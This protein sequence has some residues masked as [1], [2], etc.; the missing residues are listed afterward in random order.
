MR[1]IAHLLLCLALGC[2]GSSGAGN[3]AGPPLLET[4]EWNDVD[5]DL[6]A[7]GIIDE[8]LKSRFVEEWQQSHAEKKPTLR[9]YPIRNRTTAYIN[10]RFFT[11]QLEQALVRA[12]KLTVVAAAE[13][14]AHTSDGALED[15][16]E[17][18]DDQAQGRHDA[19]VDLV[20]NGW[21][22]SQEEQ[23]AAVT[24]RSYLTSV[25]IVDVVT[26]KKLWIGQKRIRKQIPR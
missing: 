6:V 10:H 14:R 3:T 20:L 16:R 2:A 9:L 25:E 22:L 18:G 8:A 7:R 21:I 24:V 26:E 5:A 11:K 4:G 13:E 23:D 12:G 19:D 1:G 17:E 15:V